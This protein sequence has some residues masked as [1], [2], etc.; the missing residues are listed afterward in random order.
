MNGIE[1]MAMIL[2]VEGVD[3]TVCNRS[4]SLIKTTDKIRPAHFASYRGSQIFGNDDQDAVFQ[5]PAL[6]VFKFCPGHVEFVN[7][8]VFPGSTKM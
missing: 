6:A 2:K 3:V 7:P 8:H 5:K 1:A 4:H